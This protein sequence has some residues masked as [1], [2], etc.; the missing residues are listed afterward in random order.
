MIAGLYFG[1]PTSENPS[2]QGYENIG[3]TKAKGLIASKDPIVLDVRT[4]DEFEDGHVPGAV[5]VPVDELKGSTVLE[6]P[7]D[8]EVLCYCRSGHRSSWAAEY[9][10]QRGYV[11]AYNLSG[12]ILAWENRGYKVVE[13]RENKP[14]CSC[15]VLGE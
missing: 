8:E 3:P 7:K 10:S 6:I 9:L 11:Q 12:G 15:V 4:P 5:L 2:S 1:F 13:A 14:R